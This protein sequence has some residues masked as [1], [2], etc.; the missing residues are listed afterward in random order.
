MHILRSFPGRGGPST[1]KR[2]FGSVPDGDSYVN[3]GYT[4]QTGHV[5]LVV[6]TDPR[7]SSNGW[8][9]AALGCAC[10]C[11]DA[12]AGR[13]IGFIKRKADSLLIAKSD[14]QA[15]SLRCGLDGEPH[16]G[17]PY[18]G[19][20]PAA[21]PHAR[22]RMRLSESSRL[23]NLWTTSLIHFRHDNVPEELNHTARHLNPTIQLPCYGS[24]RRELREL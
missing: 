16:G 20:V 15:T 6:V 8:C 10:I 18:K 3:M 11:I 14:V 21:P 7:R 1:L 5:R 12:Y 19:H 22:S 2:Q 9:V 17:L 24:T 23:K 4:D 13:I